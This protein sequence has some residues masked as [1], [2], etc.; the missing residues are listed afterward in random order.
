MSSLDP[1]RL[2]ATVTPSA[3]RLRVE[4]DLVAATFTG[5]AEIDVVLAEAT[6]VIVLNAIELELDPPVLRAADGT[7][8]TGAVALDEELERATLTFPGE[9]A[10]GAYVLAIEFTG[11]LNDE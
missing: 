2:P 10:P 5:T 9:L 6:S 3:Y 1:Y 8:T 7:S 4:P 11:R